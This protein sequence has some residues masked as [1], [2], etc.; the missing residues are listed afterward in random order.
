MSE[1]GLS[2]VSIGD[3]AGKVGRGPISKSPNPK[4]DES[5]RNHDLEEMGSG[6][7][8]HLTRTLM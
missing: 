3:A 4:G 6:G 5:I 7:R 8:W 1:R 2:N